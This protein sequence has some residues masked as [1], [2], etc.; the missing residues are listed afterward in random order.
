[1]V[2]VPTLWHRRL[3]GV[4]VDYNDY[5]NDS[6]GI[7]NI[8]NESTACS[9]GCDAHSITTNPLLNSDSTLQSSSPA[10]GAGTNLTSLGI[11]GLDTGAPQYFGV[12]YAC[13]TGCVA[14]LSSGAWDMG[15]YEASSGGTGSGS[16]FLTGFI[17]LL[18][19]LLIL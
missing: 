1:M 14:R 15:A 4:T 2:G 18:G 5:Y 13:G 12:N 6:S 19:H 3:S 16:V 8:T 10:K 9:G 7:T 11:T 17:K